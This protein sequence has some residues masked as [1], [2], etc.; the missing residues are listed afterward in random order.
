[1]LGVSLT[2]RRARSLTRRRVKGGLEVTKADLGDITNLRDLA[3]LEKEV[4]A[5]KR[6]SWTSLAVPVAVIG[7]SST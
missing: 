5:S 7:I 3:A 1:M 2:P 6:P 4:M